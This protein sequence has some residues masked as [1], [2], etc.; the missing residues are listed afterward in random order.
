MAGDLNHDGN[1]D[2]V[3]VYYGAGTPDTAV[4]LGKGDGTFLA[5][6][7]Y[8]LGTQGN[9]TLYLRD[10]D[11]DGNLDL[12]TNVGI[13]YGNRAAPSTKWWILRMALP[14]TTS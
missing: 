14:A 4:L 10:M 7:G 3:A 12:V 11:N 8:T 1:I 9:G 2:L 5:A 6:K 13:A